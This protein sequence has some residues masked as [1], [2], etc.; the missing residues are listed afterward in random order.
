MGVFKGNPNP[1]PGSVGKSGMINEVIY[2]PYDQLALNIADITATCIN[3]LTPESAAVPYAKQY[4]LE[5][6]IKILQARV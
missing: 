5:E 1:K 2:K 6:V 3:K 4:V